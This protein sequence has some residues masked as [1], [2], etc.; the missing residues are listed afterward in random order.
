MTLPCVGG[1]RPSPD[2]PFRTQVPAVRTPA[3][4]PCLG[5]AEKS[6]RGAE[7]G[8][9][10][11]LLT[12][13]V[14]PTTSRPAPGAGGVEP[15][16]QVS[17]PVCSTLCLSL[18]AACR[19]NGALASSSCYSANATIHHGA[20][21]APAH[22][23][24]FLCKSAVVVPVCV[25]LKALLEKPRVSLVVLLC[26]L[27]EVGYLRPVGLQVTIWTEPSLISLSSNGEG[28]LG[29]P[30]LGRRGKDFTGEGEMSAVSR[31]WDMSAHSEQLA[32]PRLLCVVVMF[33][34]CTNAFS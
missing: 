33:P 4:L 15:R 13:A 2:F 20:G 11:T 9:A 6:L 16:P 30:F 17:Q 25:S 28:A 14:R 26:F 12:A 19:V 29:I 10:I 18:Y 31:P 3:G 27:Y 22:T 8:A 34:H 23:A 7:E 24:G 32:E 1:T 21:G 5:C